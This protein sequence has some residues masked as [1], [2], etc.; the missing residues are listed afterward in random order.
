MIIVMNKS[1]SNKDVSDVIHR[2]EDMGYQVHLSRGTERTIIGVIGDERVLDS[3]TVEQLSGVDKIVPILKQ[4]KL[5]SREFHP[6]NSQVKVDDVVIGGDEIVVMAGPCSVENS[7]QVLEAAVTSK[8]AGA[9]VLRGGAFKPRTS[10][11]SF[12]GLGEDGLKLLKEAK[13]KTGLPII[14]EVMATD[15]VDLVARYAD[16]LQI[17]ARNVQNYNLLQAVGETQHPVL[18][19][20]GFA[21]TIDELLLAAEYILSNGNYQV[22]LCERG[23]RSFDTKYT[24]NMLDIMA[25]PILKELTHL[26]VIVD[27]SHSTGKWELVAAASRAA[28]AAGAD[29]LLVEVHPDPEVALSDGRQSLKPK[30]F[31]AMMQQIKGI[32]SAV[33]RTVGADRTVE[34]E[35]VT[36]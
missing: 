22:M 25:V 11:Y 10:P 36:N 16:I 26:P 5:A 12:Q 27:P 24:R 18:L 29:G 23:V 28:V 13:E 19:K 6:E 2:V 21:T 33:G 31:A 30:T 32:A 1:A 4:Y 7:D 8:E 9:K 14:T 15:Q 35:M 20:R 3:Q 17:G 34:R